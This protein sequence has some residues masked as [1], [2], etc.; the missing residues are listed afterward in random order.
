MRVIA[1]TAKGHPLK[2][3][4]G[5]VTRPTQDRVKEAVFSSLGNRVIDAVVLDLFAGTGA[6]G[7][8]A[9]SRGAARCYFNDHNR[10][11]YEL[12]RVNLQ[13][14]RL[15]EK[16]R[17]FNRDAFKLL[18]EME[19]EP[20]LAFDL[21][22]LDPPYLAGFY[23]PLLERL[24]NSSLLKNGSYLIVES[25]PGLILPQYIC[26]LQ[27]YKESKYGDTYIRYFQNKI[28]IG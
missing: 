2:S 1:G 24:A 26:N 6:I 27:L 4:K 14:C 17:I 23:L 13:K 15:D 9:L 21:V 12:I 18:D 11:A 19:D 22:Y 28:N 5:L 25:G 3:L 8:E 10:K 7:I 20:E 16:S